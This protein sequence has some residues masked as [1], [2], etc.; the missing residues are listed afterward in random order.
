MRRS[1]LLMSCLCA[2]ASGLVL[3]ALAQDLTRPAIPA[4]GAATD[5]ADE[6]ELVRRFYAAANAVLATGDADLLA[7]TVAPDL[8]EHPAR[9]GPLSGRDGLVRELLSMRD[10]FPGLILV[11][12]DVRVAG[13]DQIL[14]HVHAEGTVSG[15]FMGRPVPASL[16]EWGPL[17]VWRVENG[18]LAERWV[19]P[20]ATVLLPLGQATISVDLLGPERRRVTV[21]RLTAAPGA[22]LAVDNGPAIRVFAVEAGTLTFDIGT[23]TSGPVV[24]AR[25]FGVATP[26]MPAEAIAVAVGDLL[27]TPPEADYTLTNTGTVPA[28]ALVVVVSN[29]AGGGSPQSNSMAAAS[30]EVAAMPEALGGAFPSPFGFAASVLASNVELTMPTQPVL[31]IGWTMLA[32]G[33]MLALPPGD[34]ALLAVVDAGWIGLATDGNPATALAAGEWTVIPASAGS[35]WQ[36]GGDAHAA[37]L[38]LTVGQEGTKASGSYAP[39]V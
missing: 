4:T 34:E 8:D 6:V 3:L 28:V 27:A 1:V 36:D 32:P 11:V 31:A 14:A 39:R 20:A 17:E 35:I 5:R 25:G 33:A 22:T 26:V 30:W 37:V 38:V 24:A 10:T 19:D 9:S 2:L 7:T 23:R 18:R 16:V 12:E 21:I 29:L 15:T 13:A